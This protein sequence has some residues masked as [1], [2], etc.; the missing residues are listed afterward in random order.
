VRLALKNFR[1]KTGFHE[2]P[3]CASRSVWKADP[4]NA[5]EETLHLILRVSPYRCARCDMRFMDSKLHS[6]ITPPTRISRWLT[7]ARSL[8]SRAMIF[9]RKAPFQDELRLKLHS[10]SAPVPTRREAA[11]P[12]RVEH[13][14]GA[15]QV[16]A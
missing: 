16:R 7:S 12:E 9:S 3:R 14:A 10:F 11:L 13:M 2:C 1:N 4:Q 15:P 8:A 5:L 6:D